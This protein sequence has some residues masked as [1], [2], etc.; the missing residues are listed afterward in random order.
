MFDGV[1]DQTKELHDS[2]SNDVK[3]V[4]WI[5]SSSRHMFLRFAVSTLYSSTGFLAKIYFGNLILNQKLVN[6]DNIVTVS[7]CFYKYSFGQ[8]S[9]L[10]IYFAGYIH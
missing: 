7:T 3:H 10:A 1:C 5:H 9:N 8:K 4:E 6:K 2:I